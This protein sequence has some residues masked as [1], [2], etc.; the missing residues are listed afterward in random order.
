MTTKLEAALALVARGWWVFPCYG[1]PRDPRDKSPAGKK[2]KAPLGAVV[3]RGMSG[4]SNDPRV[5]REWWAAEPSANIGVACGPSG[6]CVLDVDDPTGEMFLDHQDVPET[7]EV[8]TGKGRHLYFAGEATSVNRVFGDDVGVD[9][10]SLG[11]YVIAPGSVHESGRVYEFSDPD[12]AVVDAPDWLTSASRRKTAAESEKPTNDN[13][14]VGEGRRNEFLST[15]AFAMRRAGMDPEDIIPALVELNRS[16]CTPPLDRTEVETIA[17]GKTAVAPLGNTVMGP[18][19]VVGIVPRESELWFVRRFVAEH[20]HRLKY[21]KAWNAWQ[22]Y[23]ET[24]GRWIDDATNAPMRLVIESAKKLGAEAFAAPDKD[25]RAQLLKIAT[26]Y[27]GRKGITNALSVAMPQHEIY[28]T[29]SDWDSDPYLLNCANGVVD[30][31]SGKLRGHS[32]IDRMRKSAGVEYDPDA[33]CPRFIRFLEE[34]LPDPEVRDFMHRVIGYS[35]IGKVVE[36]IM[37]IAWGNGAN[38]KSVLFNTIA[39]ALGDYS[40]TVPPSLITINK[41]PLHDTVKADLYGRRLAIASE[42]P[43]NVRLDEAALKLLTGGD[44]IKARRLYENQW[45]FDPS[46]TLFLHTNSKPTVTDISFGL[47]RR[48]RLVPFTQKFD[49][50]T[51]DITLPD[52]LAAELPGILAWIVRG[53]KLWQESGLPT[54]QVVLQATEEY[55]DEEDPLGDFANR[56]VP[57][58]SGRIARTKI[59]EAYKTWAESNG[60]KPWVPNTLYAKLRNRG[61]AESKSRGVRTFAVAEEDAAAG[62][63][64]D[65]WL[66]S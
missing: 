14:A 20:S 44:R 34:V 32:V 38:G 11:G 6:L 22:V 19:G 39:R 8:R 25:E 52:K 43:D 3:P 21:V 64:V 65:K 5:V 46:H 58:A 2:C 51:K 7:L 42:N 12:V 40:C 9:R 29:P 53:A 48:M 63:L 50:P 61:W 17:R 4:A 13:G 66:D 49:G 16:R 59:Y 56:Y 60:M 15:S 37:V 1:D 10:K 54:P 33:E 31:R 24:E 18:D 36:H 23:E 62:V 55:R 47:W 41:F 35:A 26:T 30:L 57:S 45:E 27:M 28:A